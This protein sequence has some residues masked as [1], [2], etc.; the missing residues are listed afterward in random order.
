MTAAI[1]KGQLK[2]MEG[3]PGDTLAPEDF[4]K[5]KAQMKEEFGMEPTSE[6]LNAFLMYP[7]V[8]RDYKKHLAKAGPLATYLPTAAFFYGLNVN[9]TIDFDVPGANV[10]D[11][12]AKND[13]S[14]PRSK[15]SIQLTRVGPLEHD[16]R[17]CEWLVDGTTYQVSI[18]DPP[19]NASYAG[20]MADPSNKTHVSCPL[21]GVIRSVVKEGAELKKDDILFTVVAMKMEVV[22]RAPAACEVTEVCVG[23]EAE[24]VD[25]A[26]LA[27][28]TMLEEETLPGA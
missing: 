22:V 14:L 16:M 23:M 20:P 13:A 9:E 6:D 1:L 2:P 27:K 26:L 7:G 17:T 4:E 10:M 25:G 8:F 28:L 3:R 5:V 15:A 19:K 11:A 21:P 12:E 18:K 24:V